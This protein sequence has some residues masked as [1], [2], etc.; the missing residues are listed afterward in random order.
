[1]ETYKTRP[2]DWESDF[3]FC[4]YVPI[5]VADVY[6]LFTYSDMVNLWSTKG[7]T[8]NGNTTNRNRNRNRIGGNG[9]SGGAGGG[10]GQTTMFFGN[11]PLRFVQVA[12]R[13]SHI[14]YPIAS[15]AFKL[16]K[17]SITDGTTDSS[18]ECISKDPQFA[19]DEVVTQG[20]IVCVQG[21]LAMF[22][23]IQ[24]EV[25][26]VYVF[27]PNRYSVYCMLRQHSILVR[28]HVLEWSAEAF[29][30][31]LAPLGVGARPTKSVID[32]ADLIDRLGPDI[33]ESEAILGLKPGWSSQSV[34]WPQI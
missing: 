12:G 5:S 32:V 28:K 4:C 29:E 33:R 15:S 26:K 21:N 25:H 10:G 27:H 6:N 3:A 30:H 1:M 31:F 18:L 19:I 23:S 9:V 13:V 8:P 2:K 14:E 24:V 16:S 20:A 17:F 11:H 22:D 7:N 34:K